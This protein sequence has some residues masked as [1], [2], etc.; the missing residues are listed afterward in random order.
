MSYLRTFANKFMNG[1]NEA[2][3][4]KPASQSTNSSTLASSPQ[5]TYH[6]IHQ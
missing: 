1:D 3:K 2:D 6:V 4:Q 5:C